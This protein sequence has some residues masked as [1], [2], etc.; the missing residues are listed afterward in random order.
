MP[1]ETDNALLISAA[2]V[3]RRIDIHKSKFYGMVRGGTFPLRPIH[4]GRAVKYRADELARWVDAGC[5]ASTRWE[6]MRMNAR[7]IG[8]AA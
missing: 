8:G 4:L 3:C 2:E 7:R 1:A 6:A 5:P